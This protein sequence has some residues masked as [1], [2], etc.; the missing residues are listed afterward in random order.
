MAR[1]LS[2]ACTDLVSP[3]LFPRA[4]SYARLADRATPAVR[5]PRPLPHGFPFTERHLQCVWFDPAF[6]PARLITAG[7]EPVIVEDPG[8][9]N[10]EAGPDFLG[11]ALRI[12]RE[13]RR[14]AGDVEIHVHP[15][16]WES[17][18]HASD[19]RYRRVRVHV[20]Y[21]PGPP[22]AAG[23]QPGAVQISLRDALAANP[24]FSFEC[25]DVTAYPRAARAAVPPCSKILDGWDPRDRG[26]LLDAAGEERLRRK[27]E[28]F[29]A[30]VV[31]RGDD[32]V[33]YEEVMCA[34]GY[35]HNKGP[36]RRLAELVPVATLREESH[37]K[38]ETAYALLMG[39]AGLLP[40]QTPS[41]WDEE[42]RRFVR[43]LW[44]AWWKRRERWDG[45]TLSRADWRLAGL[46]PAN[47]PERRLMAAACLFSGRRQE[48]DVADLLNC[49]E[50]TYWARRLG[51][52]GKLQPRPVAL[53][54]RTRV[55]A[56]VN[57]VLVPFLAA[58]NEKAVFEA[59][60]LK[61]LPPEEYNAIVEQTARS[62]FGPDHSAALYR[63]GLRR[64]G[65]IQVFHD[66]CLND[67]SRCASCP[68][69]ELLR[70][71]PASQ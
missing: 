51:L 5:E 43:S 9:W 63:D 1:S 27:A 59:G 8:L 71:H 54:G 15:S 66:F 6:R 49:G 68:L 3:A 34:L 46:R 12:G 18:G 53:I 64:Q 39:V 11:A 60:L 33:L 47:R 17:H 65:L 48:L 2:F 30:A 35:K 31:E 62:L 69:P 23:L 26:A 7:G 36:F 52:G 50:G 42:T 56:V 58:K 40:E 4:A 61:N 10:S 38:P 45:R 24:L 29:A 13:Q 19:P 55:D 28:R 44:N 16:D 22:A 25:I 67:R 21:F 41:R 57:N 70:G 37:G 32:Q 20:T 14:I